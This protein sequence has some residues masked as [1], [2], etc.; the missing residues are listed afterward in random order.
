LRRRSWDVIL[1]SQWNRKRKI[2]KC[3][4]TTSSRNPKTV[5]VWPTSWNKTEN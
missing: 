2:R 3:A 1:K 5:T 4:V